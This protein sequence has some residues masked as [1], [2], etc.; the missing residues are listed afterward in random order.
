MVARPTAEL[1]LCSSQNGRAVCTL[2]MSYVA[3]HSVLKE[4]QNQEMSGTEGN[5]YTHTRT[6]THTH[7]HTHTPLNSLSSLWLLHVLSS[8]F[9]GPFAVLQAHLGSQLLVRN[10]PGSLPHCV[11]G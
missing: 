8:K 11:A 3:T 2:P 7:T 6:H 1:R 9:L 5:Q 4:L 10:P